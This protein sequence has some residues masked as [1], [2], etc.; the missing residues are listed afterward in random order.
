MDVR[1]YLYWSSMGNDEWF[2]GYQGHF[3]V[4][5]VDRATWRCSIR[6]RAAVL[7]GIAPASGI[8]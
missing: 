3:G 2:N 5:G 8:A 4:L 6:A 7:G 1:G